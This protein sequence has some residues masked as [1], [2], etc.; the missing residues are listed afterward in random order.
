MK[1]VINYNIMFGEAPKLVNDP[2]AEKDHPEL[3]TTSELE[4]VCL[5]QYQS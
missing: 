4:N 3:D 2:L 1:M 5:K